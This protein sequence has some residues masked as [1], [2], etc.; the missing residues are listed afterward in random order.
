[1]CVWGGGG[2]ILGVRTLTPPPPFFFWGGGGGKLHKE[3]GN[4]ACMHR[5]CRVLVV[6]WTPGL[7]FSHAQL[8]GSICVEEIEI[9]HT[10]DTHR[11]TYV[12]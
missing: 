7:D 9:M 11:H 12:H 4:V 2:G 3:G 10:L 8:N 1:M 6:T 5:T